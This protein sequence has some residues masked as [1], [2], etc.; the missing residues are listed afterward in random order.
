M[1]YRMRPNADPADIPS[2]IDLAT[3]ACDTALHVVDLPYRLC[4]WA[5]DE[6][7]SVGLWMDPRGWIAAWAVLQFPFW[8]FDIAVHPEAKPDLFTTA[9]DWAV[10]RAKGLLGGP[11]ERPC[12][13]VL[14]FSDQTDRR[15]ALDAAGFICQDDVG[16]DSWS[17]VLL[18]HGSPAACSPSR[19]EGFTIRSLSGAEE[20]EAYVAAHR[21]AF[22]SANMTVDW[23]ARTLSAPHHLLEAD[24]VAEADDGQLAGFCI[25]WLHA[26]T[27]TGQIE[28]LGVLP[29]FQRKGLGAAL[30]SECN[31]QLAAHGATS[32]LVATDSF[33]NPAR[34]LYEAAGFKAT[35]EILVFRKDFAPD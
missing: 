14:A 16:E 10:H 7:E 11:T 33:R 15:R 3:S 35:R 8:T 27:R 31:A 19:V 28:P 34:D 30:V 2:M 6:P 5:L 29:G 9:L 32:V 18:R 20:V 4:S 21:E 13:Y 1:A 26:E 22:G 17:Q 23:R 12:W 25:G 24:L